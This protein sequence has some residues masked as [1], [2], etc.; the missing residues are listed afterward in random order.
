MAILINLSKGH[1]VFNFKKLSFKAKGLYVHLSQMK[2]KHYF[3]VDQLIT[4]SKDNRASIYAGLKELENNNLLQRETTRKDGKIHQVLYYLYAENLNT[5]RL[6]EYPSL[7]SSNNISSSISIKDKASVLSFD[8][9]QT[10]ELDRLLNYWQKNI[11]KHLLTGKTFLNGK[12]RLKQKY[13]HLN[14]YQLLIK[15]RRNKVSPGF[16]KLMI[17]MRLYKKLLRSE[18]TIFF[19]SLPYKVSLLDFFNFSPY[20]KRNY[21]SV[22]KG[23][24]SWYSECSRGEEYCFNKYSRYTTLE[25]LLVKKY[26]TRDEGVIGRAAEKFASF[27]NLVKS[28]LTLPDDTDAEY[29]NRFLR[30][31]FKFTDYKFRSRKFK[32]Y[33]LLNDKFLDVD[34]TEYLQEMDWLK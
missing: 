15:R 11:T 33:F 27:H 6:K 18:D 31:L 24:G 3:N 12:K 7:A 19:S 34:F 8:T 4:T 29:P 10:E 32:L 14:R 9:F 25:K 16:K 22:I 17:A 2:D 23:I 20:I 5:E 13:E 28:D 30:Y 1:N 21:G 26:P